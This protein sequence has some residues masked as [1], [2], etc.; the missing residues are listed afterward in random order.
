VP[1][2][3]TVKNMAGLL[4]FFALQP[5]Q[6]G[7]LLGQGNW[8]GDNQNALIH[9]GLGLASGNGWGEGAAN[10]LKGFAS[11]RTADQTQA[12][13]RQ[14]NQMLSGLFGQQE[15]PPQMPQQAM[16]QQA[17]PQPSAAPQGDPSLPRGYRNANPLNIEDGPFAR[18]QPGYAGTDG[19]FAK[20]ASLD[21]GAGAANSLLDVYQNKHGLN[22]VRG[23]IG[24][25]APASDG[26][27]VNAY[28][29]NVSRR[30]GV[31][32]DDPIPPEKRQQLIAAMAQHENGRPM[33]QM[34]GPQ[35]ASAQVPLGTTMDQG[36]LPQAMPQQ[37]P[38]P[39]QMA[40]A[41]QQQGMS[42]KV[43]GLMRML[44]IPNLPESQRELAKMLLQREMMAPKFGFQSTPDG[45]I[46]RTDERSGAV[47]PAYQAPPKP[48]TAGRD[49]R[50]LDPVTGRV[51]VPSEPEK[52]RQMSVEDVTKLQSEAS[53][54]ANLTG[55]INEFKPEYAGATYGLGDA[56][57]LIGRT[58]PD[59]MVDPSAQ[60]GAI[61]WQKYD[62]YK[63][64]VRNELF[65]SALT[66]SEQAAFERAD[67]NN[68]MNPKVIK[69]NLEMQR[70]IVE[71]A[72]KNRAA[73]LISEGF[74]PE[75]IAK[76]F[77]MNPKDLQSFIDSSGGWT[78]VGGVR[79][80]ERR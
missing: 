68:T 60:K 34:G 31:S 24:R 26:N 58:A 44:S 10:A 27:N 49:Q 17:Q 38:Q 54:F 2:T 30:L 5:Q 50:V 65:G 19:R 67:V 40:Q 29:E 61:F 48:I 43:L 70:S 6:G 18:S 62:R 33:P 37:Q 71:K 39:P 76:A 55:F 63:N 22:T 47:T 23:I 72:L 15:Q 53:K 80:R 56:R 8:F 1:H 41:P 78:D 69:E 28:V 7:G 32:P 21:Q 74:R 59:W 75:S 45:T 66:P 25:W 4:D 77:G 42:P 64:V 79:I 16:P 57:N 20:F 36:P 12:A 13:S 35:M 14:F 11:G 9:M 73:A 52:P 51:I 46:L 3:D